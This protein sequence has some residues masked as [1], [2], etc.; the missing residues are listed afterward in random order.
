MNLLRNPIW[1]L[2]L[3]RFSL[4]LSHAVAQ[5]STSTL[6]GTV[7][8][9]EGK[10]VSGVRIQW[11]QY[12][13]TVVIQSD[14][15]GEFQFNFAAP[16]ER[17]IKFAHPTEAKTGYLRIVLRPDISLHVAAIVRTGTANQNGSG[18][19]AFES[20]WGS[21]ETAAQ[22][23]VVLTAS[24]VDSIPGTGQ[25][26]SVLS[27]MNPSVVAERFDIS[28]LHSNRQQLLGAH[29]SSWSQNQFYINGVPLNHPSGEGML[30][31]AEMSAI[32]ATVYSIGNSPTQR[33][34]PGAAIAFIP[35][36][37]DDEFH[38]Q[39][40]LFFQG[41]ALQN[42]NASERYRFFRITESDERWH[43]YLNGGLQLGGPLGNR[44]WT[45]FG[46]LAVRDMA[47]RIRN[48]PQLVPAEVLQGAFH[49]SG[50][51]SARDT[52]RLFGSAQG[53]SE[54]HAELTPQAAFESSLDRRSECYTWQGAWTRDV[55]PAGQ[56]DLRLAVTSADS[57]SRFQAGVP[58][59]SSEDLFPGYATAGLPDSPSPW[60]MLAMLDN[61]SRGPAPLANSWEAG[62]VSGVA[63]YTAVRGGLWRSRH[64][65][66]AG[67]IYER[68]NLAQNASAVDGVN[69]LFFE[70]APDSVRL[71]TTPSRTREII[72]Q[73][74]VHASDSV[75]LAGASLTVG[76][77]AG[78][79]GG[80]SILRTGQ[81]A[82]SLRWNNVAG[83]LG[84][85]YHVLRRGPVVLRASAARIVHQPLAG[86]WAAA[87]PEGLEVRLFSWTDA[88]GD[89]LFQTGENS[90]LLKV[91]G[92]PS[93][94]LD[95]KLENPRTTE[96][97]AGFTAGG[98]GWISFQFSGFHR[99]EH[100]VMS[101]INEGVPFSSYAPVKV[102]YAGPDGVAGTP[103][104]SYLPAFNQKKET[105]GKDRY[106]LTN[107]EGFSA[108]AQGLELKLN[109]SLANFQA[110]ASV[111]RMRA[112]A[113]TAPG[114]LP[115]E[116]DTSDYLGVYDDPNKALLAKG[117]TY[118]DRGTLG[119]LW[120]TSDLPGR[121]RISM[122]FSYQ[123]GLPYASYLPVK[124]LNQGT[125]AV[126][127]TQRG[128]GARGS[129]GGP[130][131][132]YNTALNVR[133]TREFSLE[134]GSISAILDVFNLANRSNALMETFVASPTQYW[135][136]P[137]S[138]QTPR[139]LQLGIRY[140]W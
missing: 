28:G 119:R 101:I 53:S 27:D 15:K 9:D 32:E 62:S 44:P 131:T 128:P 39:A 114:I 95:P 134:R 14:A 37:G 21:I 81:P 85:A 100:S 79:S 89:R 4:P 55:S 47:K 17:L 115:R 12:G 74:E 78:S 40:Q 6:S 97:T 99:S 84:V 111:V 91:Y 107:P 66:S 87:N 43:R 83:Q 8:D 135:R 88:N 56:L 3:I 92:P 139:S 18:G 102:F 10:P 86:T 103:D 136:I 64:R 11:S 42:T 90:Q 123:D 52:F 25:Y 69:L 38:G 76:F 132:T 126:L 117:S 108:Y 60:D 33:T 80:K 13:Q 133:M 30:L 127:T 24:R 129:V 1:I 31:F 109:L 45:Y 130:R 98:N 36:A 120:A 96:F 29:G 116:N 112:V 71:L 82:N 77:S 61:T 113:S 48:H 7:S 138:Y 58:G 23:Q 72:N 125:I 93:T 68:K 59:Q 118:F 110:E 35:K 57:R 106:V 41:G 54:P 65:F 26:W 49:L 2:L 20:R 34:A 73:A 104:D 50:R 5:D 63:E 140:K 46:S 94:R 16:G 124:G 121:I 137:L 19:W 75:S 22:P 105:L 70:G 67:A 51:L 122:I